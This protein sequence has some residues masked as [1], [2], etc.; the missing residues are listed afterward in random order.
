MLVFVEPLLRAGMFAT[1]AE[2][3]AYTY[4]RY[5]MYGSG[6]IVTLEYKLLTSTTL[7]SRLRVVVVDTARLASGRRRRLPPV[8]SACHRLVRGLWPCGTRR[9]CGSVWIASVLPALRCLARQGGS[10]R[11][12]V[13]RWF[14]LRFQIWPGGD[15][16][17]VTQCMLN[18]E[19]LIIE[20][21]HN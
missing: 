2:R 11:A 20:H 4:G 8:Q 3:G 17:V 15:G 9:T 7:F 14:G 10:A 6:T 21:G 18:H 13:A 5:G 19:S 12:G 1:G 16:N